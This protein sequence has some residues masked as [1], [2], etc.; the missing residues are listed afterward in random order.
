M[1]VEVLL[2][3]LNLWILRR[4]RLVKHLSNLRTNSEIFTSL[5][6]LNQTH[7]TAIKRWKYP[8]IRVWC[9]NVTPVT[10]RITTICHHYMNKYT[11]SKW[12]P[13]IVRQKA[14]QKLVLLLPTRA[15]DVIVVMV[16]SSATAQETNEDKLCH[17]SSLHRHPWIWIGKTNNV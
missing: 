12:H 1:S 16:S 7:V 5:P 11:H 8:S 14:D 6:S 15:R 4:Q 17:D 13:H 3:F 9:S 2:F 10:R